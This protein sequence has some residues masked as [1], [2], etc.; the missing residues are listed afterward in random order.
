MMEEQTTL[1][2]AHLHTSCVRRN[3]GAVLDLR[4]DFGRCDQWIRFPP[5]AG[6]VNVTLPLD[7]NNSTFHRVAD[8]VALDRTF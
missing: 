4:N 3:C 6:L 1:E 2:G 8:G 5:S 7:G